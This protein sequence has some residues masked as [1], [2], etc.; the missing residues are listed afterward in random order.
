MGASLEHIRQLLLDFDSDDELRGHEAE[1]AAAGAA[2]R[3][4]PSN[5]SV[6]R[7]GTQGRAAKVDARLLFLKRVHG[8]TFPAFDDPPADPGCCYELNRYGAVVDPTPD[9]DPVEFHVSVV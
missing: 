4:P 5:R 7:P 3:H 1:G 8:G 9:E 6:R 2:P